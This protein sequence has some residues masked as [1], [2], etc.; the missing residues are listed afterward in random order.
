[1]SPLIFNIALSALDE[2]VMEPWEPGGA[3]STSGKRAYR[4]SRG[5]PT[6]RIIRYADLCRP[7]HKSA[8]AEGGIMLTELLAGVPGGQVVVLG[9]A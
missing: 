7:R 1:L 5:R 3:M 8:Y 9:A 2:H 4:R 6:W